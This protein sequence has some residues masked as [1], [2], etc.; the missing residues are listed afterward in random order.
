MVRS[1]VFLM[2][3]FRPCLFWDLTLQCPQ[4]SRVLLVNTYGPDVMRVIEKYNHKVSIESKTMFDMRTNVNTMDLVP[5]L[6]QARC[7]Y[8]HA[9]D[10]AECLLNGMNDDQL[11]SC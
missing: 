9:F 11:F 10:I 1:S 3:V 2:R 7:G 6:T 5:A 8:C 4:N